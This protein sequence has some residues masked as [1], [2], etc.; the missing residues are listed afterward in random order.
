M[1]SQ[2]QQES[3]TEDS[4]LAAQLAKWKEQ[5]KSKD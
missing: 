2:K 1:N 5:Q 3:K 4:P